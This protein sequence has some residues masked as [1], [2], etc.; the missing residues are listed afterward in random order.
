MLG[1]L[2]MRSVPE[3]FW[4]WAATVPS[5]ERFWLLFICLT[6]VVLMTSI[7]SATIYGMHRN[8]VED[9]LKRELLDRGMTAEEIA[10]IMNKA[11]GKR[12]ASKLGRI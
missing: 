6:A 2:E 9:S 11:D 5:Q 4:D 10:T 3:N 1:E 8:R 12:G 7:V